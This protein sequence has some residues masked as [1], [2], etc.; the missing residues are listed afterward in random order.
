[1]NRSR[2]LPAIPYPW[3]VVGLCVLATMAAHSLIRGLGVLF[4]FIQD[5]LDL[6]R[7]QLGLVASV[8][9]VGGGA[10]ALLGGWLADVVGVR[11]WLTVALV[12]MVVGIILFSQVQTLM[13]AILVGLLT[14][15]AFFSTFPASAKGIVDWVT[16]R[17]RGLALGGLE[18]S[19]PVI[20]IIAAV[21]LAYLADTYSWRTAILACAVIIAISAVIFFT[22][23]RNKPQ[24]YVERK[25]GSGQGGRI[26]LVARNREIWLAAIA[27]T[28]WSIGRILGTYL[29][30]FLKEDLGMSPVV[31]GTMLAVALAGSTVGRVSWGLLSDLLL[32][33]RRVELLA[34]VSILGA[35]SVALLTWLPSD[36]ST[37]TV[38]ALVFFIGATGLGWSGLWTVLLAEIAA[39]E[40]VGT[41][42]GFA[43]AIH[44][45]LGF[46]V[47]PLFGF[48]VDRTGSYDMGWWLVVAMSGAGTLLLFFMRP[49]SR[50]S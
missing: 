10:T 9:T 12:A 32:R 3:V 6:S 33:G 41:A 45:V 38:A 8:M 1:M 46:V 20:G 19:I 26:A 43:I 47:A 31:G 50:R 14:G 27:A 17:T 25:E 11:R 18:A 13:Q 29:V 35:V 39:P 24:V 40:L 15:V 48:I 22:F 2:V 30:L 28:G 49:Q 23:Y 7:T 5:D 21:L 34:F 36:A 4:P 37:A 16:P 44:S 42:I